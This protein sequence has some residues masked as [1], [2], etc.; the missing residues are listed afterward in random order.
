MLYFTK[1]VEIN[2]NKKAFT[3]VE[4]LAVII[5]LG[6]IA[7]IAVPTVFKIIDSSKDELYNDQIVQI[8]NAAKRWTVENAY[9]EKSYKVTINELISGGYLEGTKNNKVL[10]P[11]DKS[12]MTGCVI[13][14]YDTNTNQYTYQYYAYLIH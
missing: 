4:L 6:I 10:D 13:I 14:D 8:E 3:L 5:I 11:R 9:E 12:E 7:L 2:M 1:K